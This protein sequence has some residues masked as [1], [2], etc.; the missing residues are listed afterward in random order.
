[1]D[2]SRGSV[3]CF[4]R[5]ALNSSSQA[6]LQIRSPFVR[7]GTVP[8][9]LLANTLG[10]A[11]FLQATLSAA[12]SISLWHSSYVLHWSSCLDSCCGHLHWALP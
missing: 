11:L 4:Y 3:C 5:R 12:A 1:M 9:E 6:G 2:R 10:K 7:L 8:K